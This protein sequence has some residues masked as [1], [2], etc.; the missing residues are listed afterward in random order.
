L[1]RVLITGGSGFVGANLAR[2]VLR[3]G[4]EVHLIL[5]DGY[6]SWRLDEIAG[7]FRP[8]S[9]A[10]EDSDGVL[11]CVRSVQPDWVFH[12]AA[13]G[14]YS[15]QTG[16]QKM[17]A[18]N[19]LGTTALV[20]ACAEVGVESFVHTGSSSEY[21]YKDHAAQEDEILRPNSHY[22]VT[23]AAATHYCQLVAAERGLKAI[24]VRLY[25]VFGPYEE[26]ARLIPTVVIHGMRGTFPPLAAPRIARD[27]VYVDDAVEAILQVARAGRGGEIY[28]VST[29]VQSSLE[30]VVDTARRLMNIPAAPVWASMPARQWDTDMWSGSAEFMARETGW[31]ARIDFS[32]GLEGMTNWF[33][34]HPKWRAFYEDRILGAARKP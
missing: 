32:Q 22:A 24:T 4:H 23:K 34:Q 14:A 6:R 12:L 21:G 31:R 29:G 19:L 20:D 8:H 27:F 7:E 2:R 11:N 15:T 13:F 33:V 26:P 1:K 16:I 9:I 25:S 28:N 10:V 18:T 3:D 30:T 5:R 17:I